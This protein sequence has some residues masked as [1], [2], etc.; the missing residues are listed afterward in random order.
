MKTLLAL[1]IGAVLA[2]STL[3]SSTASAVSPSP[4]I[5]TQ[6]NVTESM[7]QADLL[8]VLVPE[9]AGE[10]RL[11][12][13]DRSSRNHI[14]RAISVAAFDGKAGSQLDIVA[15]VGLNYGRVLLLGVGDT[16]ELSRAKAEEIG[17][18]L[19]NWV[20][21]TKAETVH[22]H[23]QL[24]ANASD[25]HR[26]AAAIAHGVELRNYRF[27]RFKS[28]PEAR[29]AQRYSWQVALATEAR[30]KI[31]QKQALAQGVFTAREL[32]NL[33]GSSG[34]PAAFA[35]FAKAV[36]EPLGVE[37]TILGPEDIQAL[38]MGSL[39]GVSQGSHMKAHLLV[40]RWRGNDDDAPIALVGKG[41][42]F[43]TGGYNLKT[44]SASILR[45]HTDKAGGAAVVGAI[46]AL[47]GQK[48]QAHVVGVV[49]LSINMISGT[50]QLPGDVVTAGDGST[51]EIGNTDAEGRLILA[52]GIW[53]AREHIKPRAIVDIA[54]LTGAKVGA[55][56]TEY[57]AVFT[58]D[59]QIEASL[60]EAG[61]LVQER[62][63]PLPLDGYDN[64]VRSRIADRINTGS[65]G[66]QAGAIF[67]QHFAG[68]IPWA[69]I[70]MAGDAF[71]ASANGIHPEGS[72]G[73]GVR[74]LTEWVKL[75]QA[76]SN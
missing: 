11:T 17:A 75:Y 64:I 23:S 8:V 71:N 1:S 73:Y 9:N 58:R 3:L 72:S 56:G 74:L 4:Y 21:G 59:Q 19:S 51:I 45:M 40:A 76:Q 24:I 2:G 25:N 61:N 14:N 43:D 10:L 42:T 27:D 18:N 47:A 55:L 46:Q 7:Q 15:P 16:A 49:P 48:A 70:D 39:Y 60:R 6:F 57:S 37:V 52:D 13:W 53:Y 12:G 35:N 41:N 28:Q 34:Y 26:I 67:L 33:P 44:Q 36:L 31:E 32:T 66:A 50:A 5:H 62:V 69:H 38:G 29:P 22:V 20:N 65:P 68:D 63:W 54:T 30:A